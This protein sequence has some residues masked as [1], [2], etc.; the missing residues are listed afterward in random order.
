MFP[1]EGSCGEKG[2]QAVDVVPTVASCNNPALGSDVISLEAEKCDGAK[3]LSNPGPAVSVATVT[4]GP[5]GVGN[6]GEPGCPGC[7]NG[8]GVATVTGVGNATV[9]ARNTLGSLVLVA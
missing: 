5:V 7:R 2:G 3:L 8:L 1:K 4:A 9:G 6:F